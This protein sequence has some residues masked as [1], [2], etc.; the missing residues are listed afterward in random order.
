MNATDIVYFFL[1]FLIALGSD[2]VSKYPG[3][4]SFSFHQTYLSLFIPFSIYLSFTLN[5]LWEFLYAS[6]FGSR[7]GMSLLLILWI[8]ACFLTL[9]NH[10]Q[11]TP[12]HLFQIL[13]YWGGAILWS[14][15]GT[16]TDERSGRHILLWS[17]SVLWLYVPIEFS[18]FPS[19][20]L[21]P[22][23]ADGI[24][25]LRIWTMGW[26]LFLFL[27]VW[28]TK[29]LGFD[30][31]WNRVD[32]K[33]YAIY[34]T[35]LGL[36][37]LPIGVLLRILHY[38][39]AVFSLKLLI[40]FPSIY[41]VTALP[42]EFLFRGLIQNKLERFMGPGIALGAASVLFGLAHLN[43]APAAGWKYF[44]A[45][46]LAGLAYGRT[47]QKTGKI[48]LAALVHASVNWLGLVLF[49]FQ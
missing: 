44:L 9:S 29:N 49:Q 4:E 25:I 27:Y 46:T 31:R 24:P 20:L 28:K 19:F 14:W 21:P 33:N 5:Q 7:K 47:Y 40:F 38:H 43:Q 11:W 23:A 3:S 22:E 42:E 35:A 10:P 30:F 36:L 17:L 1:L 37:L 48:T 18:W 15:I 45:A 13:V 6:Y 8:L 41:F 12:G 16:K 32:F 26:A 39:P 2:S 34:T